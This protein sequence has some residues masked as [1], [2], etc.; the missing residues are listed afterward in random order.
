MTFNKCTI[1]G[2]TYGDIGDDFTKAQAGLEEVSQFSRDQEKVDRGST[3][4][5]RSCVSEIFTYLLSSAE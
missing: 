5:D 2:K 3:K 4:C 1:K